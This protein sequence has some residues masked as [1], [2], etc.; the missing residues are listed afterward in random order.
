MEDNQV[1]RKSKNQNDYKR[2]INSITSTDNG[3]VAE[4]TTYS[5]NEDLIHEE[6]QHDGFY[7]L[8]T[9]LVISLLS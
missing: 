3:E 4:N 8:T 5:I 9:K 2:F 7:A 1:I 6:E